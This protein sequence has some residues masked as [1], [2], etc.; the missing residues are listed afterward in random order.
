MNVG[1]SA[2][3][4]NEDGG[5]SATRATEGLSNVI[6]YHLRIA[7]EASFAA[8]ERR[9]GDTHIWPGW[10]SLLRIIHDNPGIN[11]TELS[12]AAGRDKST[13]TASLREL[14]KAGLVEK[15]RDNSDRRN[16]RLSLSQDGEKHLAELE[17]HALAHDAEIDRIVG[18]DQRTIFLDILKRLASELTRQ[19]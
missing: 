3:L 16:I 11:Q 9:V 10:Y 2:E 18:S 14:G 8:Y 6:G 12:I 17:T 19:S 7:Q 13:L 5:D 4:Q 15:T 1:L